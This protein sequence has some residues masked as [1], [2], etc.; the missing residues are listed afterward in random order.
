MPDSYIHISTYTYIYMYMCDR[1][2]VGIQ[3]ML[4]TSASAVSPGA[5]VVSRGCK[6]TSELESK[7]PAFFSKHHFYSHRRMEDKSWLFSHVP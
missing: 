6:D 2:Y 5:K 4:C 1:I 3:W 7:L